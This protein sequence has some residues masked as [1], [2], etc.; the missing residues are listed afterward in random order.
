MIDTIKVAYQALPVLVS[1]IQANMSK[2]VKLS[3]N[4]DVEWSKSWCQFDLPSHYDGLRISLLDGDGLQKQGFKNA[5]SL[6]MFEFSLQKWQSETG[7]NNKNTTLE[8]DLEAFY[9]WVNELGD[10][11][12]YNFQPDFFELY[13]VDLSQNYLLMG[14]TS[15]EEYLRAVQMK[16]SRHPNGENVT[17]YKGSIFYGSS[18]ISKKLYSKWLEFQEVEMKKKKSIYTDAYMNNERKMF[19]LSDSGKSSLYQSQQGNT[20]FD[21]TAEGMRELVAVGDVPMVHGKRA[22]SP[23]EMK[24]M[25]RMMRF[26]CGYKRNMLQRNNIIRIQDIPLLLEKYHEDRQ[27]YMS[28]QKLGQGLRLSA[29][30]YMIVDLCKRFGVNGAKSEYLKVRKE[31]SW[32][33]NKNELVKKGVYIE[34]ILREDWLSDIEQADNI[35]DF[36]LQLAA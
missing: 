2:L 34:A 35:L 30:E 7:Y 17:K 18:W 23:E 12:N 24:Q 1:L 13:R 14:E 27:R 6:V 33:K 5:R 10:A 16:F 36:E 21:W 20:E 22:L 19:V 11:L 3:P 15:V 31:R 8:K 29:T 4:G 32:Y 25:I 26:E 28:V 9:E